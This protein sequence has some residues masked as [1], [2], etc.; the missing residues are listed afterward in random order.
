MKIEGFTLNPTWIIVVILL[1][2]GF[3]LEHRLW[4]IG[5]KLERLIELFEKRSS[6]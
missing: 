4:Q 3:W 1:A 2:L 5:D 6:K